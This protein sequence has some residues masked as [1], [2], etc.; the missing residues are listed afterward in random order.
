LI[1]NL[2]LSP[3]HSTPST[4]HDDQQIGFPIEA[5]SRT[6]SGT[7]SCLNEIST[8]IDNEDDEDEFEETELEEEAL[9]EEVTPF[10]NHTNMPKWLEQ[11]PLNRNLWNLVLS[12]FKFKKYAGDLNS[13]LTS[14]DENETW[15]SFSDRLSKLA[16]R[17]A[18]RLIIFFYRSGMNSTL[19]HEFSGG[20]AVTFPLLDVKYAKFKSWWANLS[21]EEKLGQRSIKR[22]TFDSRTVAVSDIYL[23]FFL[24]FFL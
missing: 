19:R 16:Y 9:R 5:S 22:T 4:S 7:S 6:S 17:Y 24:I 13:W 8:I 14:D 12:K 18:Q 3:Q 11:D 20:V 1:E 23:I 21:P 2:Q 15:A 10:K